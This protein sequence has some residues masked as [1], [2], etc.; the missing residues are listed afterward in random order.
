MRKMPFK[1]FYRAH[2]PVAFELSI[3]YINQKLNV[4]LNTKNLCDPCMLAIR[5]DMIR[6]ISMRSKADE[7]A[8]LI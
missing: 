1:H 7:M 4:C 6:Q 2:N 8:S 3:L 5:Y